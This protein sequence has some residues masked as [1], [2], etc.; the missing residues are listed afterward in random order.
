MRRWVFALWVLAG[1]LATGSA[2]AQQGACCL[3][4]CYLCVVTTPEDCAAQGGMYFGDGSA[5]EPAP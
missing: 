5:C 4:P 1:I 2:A 3:L